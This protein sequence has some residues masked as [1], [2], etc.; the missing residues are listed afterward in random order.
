MSQLLNSLSE[1]EY[2]PYYKTYLEGLDEGN[3]ISLMINDLEDQLKVLESIPEQN[4]TYSYLKGKWS[5]AEL[6][7]HVCDCENV[8][9][10]RSLSIS[11]NDKSDLPGFDQ[12][13]WVINSNANKLSKDV[14]IG[15]FKTT[16]NHSISLY[17]SYNEE[18]LLKIGKANV[19]SFSVRALA[20]IIIGH[21]R[22]H[23]TVL[24]EN[25]LNNLA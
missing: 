20:Y 8:F 9:A 5:I 6:V 11:R 1:N 4:F 23:F 3:I 14:I 22:H 18:Q 7:L 12:D 10:Y 2:A 21:N 15:L 13:E 17:K 19:V 24:K 25:Y 16:R